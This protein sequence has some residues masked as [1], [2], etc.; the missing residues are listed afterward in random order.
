MLSILGPSLAVFSMIIS[1]NVYTFSLLLAH[2]VI[3][4]LF[5]RVI[6]GKKSKSWGMVYD[7][8]S[9]GPVGLAVV[10][11]FSKKYGDLLETQVTDRQGRF[12]FLVGAETYKVT[13]DKEKFRFPSLLDKG[14]MKYRGEDFSVKKG[15]LVKFDIPL[16]PSKSSKDDTN[17]QIPHSHTHSEE[18][19]LDIEKKK[20]RDIGELGGSDS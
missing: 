16:D 12:G 1:P 5:A 13:A 7:S 15:G 19:S 18:E 10:R 20:H 3:F 8:K 2:I 17:P 9:K 14:F 4:S 6:F 11:I